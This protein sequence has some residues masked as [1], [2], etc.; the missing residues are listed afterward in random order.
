MTLCS[1]GRCVFGRTLVRGRTTVLLMRPL[2]AL[3]DKGGQYNA[4][5]IAS[6]GASHH[7]KHASMR[8]RPAVAGHERITHEQT[9]VP[10][11]GYRSRGTGFPPIVAPSE[12]G[13][14]FM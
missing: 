5:A 9:R 13:I 2:L 11:T 7:H 12:S 6:Q 10:A 1:G 14:H 4:A 8:S 3:P